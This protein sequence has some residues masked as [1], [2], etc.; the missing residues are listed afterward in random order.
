MVEK[1]LRQN[2]PSDYFDKL[3][4]NVVQIK[5]EDLKNGTNCK[6]RIANC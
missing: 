6:S 4:V 1:A 2:D 5:N 3:K